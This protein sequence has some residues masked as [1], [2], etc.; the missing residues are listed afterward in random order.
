MRAIVTVIGKDRVGIIAAV[1]NLLS[2][3]LADVGF[4][5]VQRGDGCAEYVLQIGQAVEVDVQKRNLR[6]HAHSSFGGVG[7]GDA[8]ADDGDLAAF[9]ARHAAQQ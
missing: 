1:T 4:G 5:G 9:H 8:A 6:V 7:T 2:Q 3:T